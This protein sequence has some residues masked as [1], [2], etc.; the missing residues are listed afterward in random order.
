MISDGAS[1]SFWLTCY[2]QSDVVRCEGIAGEEERR[3]R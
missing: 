1:I 3:E 2:F